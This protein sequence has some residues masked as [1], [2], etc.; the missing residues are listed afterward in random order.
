MRDASAPPRG[1]SVPKISQIHLF[2]LLKL[3]QHQQRNKARSLL[4]V[5]TPWTGYS[6]CAGL[7][8][9][10]FLPDRGLFDS[11]VFLH[12][13]R[14]WLG[15]R[16]LLLDEGDRIPDGFGLFN[17]HWYS[18][19]LGKRR[20]FSEDGG[21]CLS[22]GGLTHPTDGHPE[23]RG[24]QCCGHVHPMGPPG[25]DAP[26]GGREIGETVFL[27]A[28]ESCLGV[29]NVQGLYVTQPHRA[30]TRSLKWGRGEP[31]WLT[32]PSPAQSL[33]QTAFH[34]L[35]CLPKWFPA[36]TGNYLT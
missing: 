29:R 12:L 10:T 7:P 36:K 13:N 34:G 25:E 30:E 22:L 21:K 27:L 35:K 4:L 3:Y 11:V 5:Q 32:V 31:Q 14:L 19:D 6:V 33:D 24:M 2:L 8:A 17:T 16:C 15:A 1:S 23:F 9:G 26:L 18:H 28:S 20:W